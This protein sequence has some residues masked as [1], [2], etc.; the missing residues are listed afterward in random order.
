MSELSLNLQKGLVGHWTMDDRDISGGTVYDRSA[1]DAPDATI[2]G[3]ITTGNT[4]SPIGEN[5]KSDGASGS[6]IGTRYY[7]ESSIQTGYSVFSWIKDNGGGS[8]RFLSTDA[9]DWWCFLRDNSTEIRVYTNDASAN[10]YTYNISGAADGNWHHVGFVWDNTVPEVRF[11]KN[12]SHLNTQSVSNSGFGEGAR[13]RY[14]ILHDGSESS[15][16]NTQQ[17]VQTDCSLS[18]VRVY[19]RPITEDEVSALYNMR[20]PRYANI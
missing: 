20:T 5:T 12:G 4:N 15:N 2:N 11:Y 10:T 6:Y 7:L 8:N 19:H 17:N 18:D 13:K 3:G 14:A 1:V 16:Y 9:S